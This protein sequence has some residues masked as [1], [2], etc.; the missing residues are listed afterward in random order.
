MKTRI[1]IILSIITVG[2]LSLACNLLSTP[3]TP[4]VTAE[5]TVQVEPDVP[6]TTEPTQPVLASSNLPVGLA[7][8]K[9]QTISFY[10]FNGMQVTQVELPQSTFPQRGRIH[11]AGTMPA[12]EGTVP[13]LYFS[14]DNGES[15]HFRDG[16]GQIFAL[17]N[18][19]SFLGL[20]GVPGQPIVAFSQLEYLDTTLR[21]KLYVGSIQTLPSAAPVNVIDDP[22]SWA[23]KPILLESENGAP[24]KDWYTRIAYGIGGDIV[25]EPRKGLFTFELASGQTIT[26]LDNN[27]SPWDISTDRNWFAYSINDTQ[28]NSMCI[29]NIQTGADVC[30]PALPAS[31]PRGAGN[32]FFSPDGSYVAWMEGDGWQM[33]VT[34]DFKTTVRV[35]Q[36]DGTMVVD[37]PMKGFED[38]AG[39]GS[40]SRAEPVEWLDDQTVIVQ[41][42][43]QEWSQ[44]ALLR[45]KVANQ[46]VSYLASGEF[47]G[48]VYP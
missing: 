10:D 32:A 15:L 27:L 46:E 28:S 42:R 18:G 6:P 9:D 12:G 23:I 29:K 7:T 8:V 39:I 26:V 5:V 3:S 22:E 1:R 24:T 19:S 44:T 35:G 38:V 2:A 30:Y 37:L 13:L 31:E 41:V 17:L 47:L 20:T 16:N 45:Y 34:P 11:I 43:G 36:M 21:S 48:L 14:L 40:I 25:Y 33:A 4:P